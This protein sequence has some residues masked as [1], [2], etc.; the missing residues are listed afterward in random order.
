MYV[1]VGR[2]S[3]FVGVMYVGL[4]FSLDDLVWAWYLRFAIG[5]GP[6]SVVGCTVLSF[7]SFP[8]P[9]SGTMGEAICFDEVA[10]TLE[11]LD[12]YVVY[13][14]AYIMYGVVGGGWWYFHNL[15]AVFVTS[16]TIARNGADPS[17]A[18]KDPPAMSDFFFFF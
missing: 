2:S 8:S 17:K 14:G 1:G 9:A 15:L 12:G 7:E 11:Y 10:T 4:K 18:M 3:A 13:V 5:F 16:R 6:K